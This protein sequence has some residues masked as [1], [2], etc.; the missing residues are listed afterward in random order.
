VHSP[1]ALDYGQCRH[2][3]DFFSLKKLP[4]PIRRKILKLPIFQTI[5][6]L[7]KILSI[8]LIEVLLKIQDLDETF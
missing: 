2:T 5:G 1:K 6:N 7:M 3:A 8:K 4:Q